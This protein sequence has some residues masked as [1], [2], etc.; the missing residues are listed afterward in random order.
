[1][2][3]TKK[4][5]ECYGCG[6]CKEIC[7]TNSIEMKEDNF[8]FKYPKINIDSCID[9]QLCVEK[10][11]YN[12]KVKITPLQK[13]YAASR[14]DKQ[15]LKDSSSGGIFAMLAE[16]ILEQNGVVYG[17]T[18]NE[19]MEPIHIGI[20][21]KKELIRLLGSKYVQSD[22]VDCFKKVKENL[23]RN[24]KVLFCGTPCQCAS[25]KEF[26]GK[27][28]N[29]EN[30]I[31]CELICHGVPSA[32]MFL[33]YI[34]L[35]ETKYNSQIIDFKFRDKSYGWSCN[36]SFYL[37]EKY[38]KKRISNRLSSYY[39][40]FLDGEIYRPSCYKC[41]FAQTKRSADI[42]L[43]DYWGIIK[44]EEKYKNSN[45][46]I[47][48]GISLVLINSVKGKKIW[49]KVEDE[50]DYFETCIEKGKKMNEPLNHPSIHSYN[51]EI[52]LRK[53]LEGGIKEVDKYFNKKLGLK[54]IIFYI[55][56]NLPIRCQNII[57]ILINKR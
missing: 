7:P 11:T 41:K 53:Y 47:E 33:D 45:L 5:D 38:L 14:K 50:I 29:I 48:N 32:K 54:R 4:E 46:N 43:G 1:M 37:K 36:G 52:I 20:E 2:Q 3:N 15:K 51:R 24:K 28:K 27:E 10:C 31:I 16:K 35:L 17:C 57:R 13:I 21:N 6:L 19:R 44:N 23:D 49:E 34:K 56:S 18:F 40:Y 25:I 55:Y 12:I 8:G 26:I 9:C 39:T 42:T 22:I 30:L